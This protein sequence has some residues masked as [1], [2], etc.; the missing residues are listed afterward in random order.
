MSP[1]SRDVVER[2]AEFSR[3]RHYRYRLERR[4]GEG[5]RVCWVLLN[6]STADER[7]DDR[8]LGRCIKFAQAWGAGSI[9]V[10]N[11]F[12]LVSTDPAALCHEPDPVGPGNVSAVLRAISRAD[13]V[14]AGWGDLRPALRE[15]ARPLV[16]SVAKGA[17]CLGLTKEGQPRHPLYVS[18]ATRRVPFRPRR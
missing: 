17:W 14:I 1:L 18:G 16:A 15:R 7:Q 3:D 9:E 5:Q 6:P 11:L 2:T 10:V 8:T 4:W 12:G 13:L